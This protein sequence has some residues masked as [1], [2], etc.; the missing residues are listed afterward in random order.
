MSRRYNSVP[1]FPEDMLRR[2]GDTR[3]IYC[4]M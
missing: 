4:I 1:G 2:K 3:V